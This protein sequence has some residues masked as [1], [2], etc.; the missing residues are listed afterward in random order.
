MWN[1]YRNHLKHLRKYSI[2]MDAHEYTYINTLRTLF[3]IAVHR[4]VATIIG[5]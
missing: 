5:Q 2:M 3:I 1:L 4:T